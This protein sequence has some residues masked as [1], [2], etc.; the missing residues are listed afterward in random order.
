MSFSCFQAF[1]RRCTL[2]THHRVPSPPS[3]WP[4]AFIKQQQHTNHHR[5]HS[6]SPSSAPPPSPQ[7]PRIPLCERP[8]SYI[9]QIAT[10]LDWREQ[11]ADRASDVGATWQG[12]QD[13]PSVEDLHTELSWLLDDTVVGMRQAPEDPW[14]VTTWRDL[15]KQIQYSTS[16]S[17]RLPPATEV[18][19]R[20]S[21]EDLGMCID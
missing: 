20:E 9:T 5:C 10:L 4:L 13:A 15:E 3:T 1:A 19:L 2:Q 8:P 18:Y 11:A 21:L 6:S 17:S 14:K 12:Q 16:T 7:P